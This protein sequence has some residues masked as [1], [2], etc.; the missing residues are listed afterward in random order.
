MKLSL[1]ID[2]IACKLHDLEKSEVKRLDCHLDSEQGGMIVP[3]ESAREF[4]AIRTVRMMISELSN[5]LEHACEKNPR[6]NLELTV[7]DLMAG[8]LFPLE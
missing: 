1:A 5:Q 2:I 7:K 4:S 8:L 3:E 6:V